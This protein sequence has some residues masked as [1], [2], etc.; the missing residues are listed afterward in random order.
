[1]TLTIHRGTHEIGGSCIELNTATTRLFLDFG[2]PL[3]DRNGAKLKSNKEIK[4]LT[5]PEMVASGMAP[6]IPYFI[7]P[8]RKPSALLLSHSH[9]D[10]YG[11]SPWLPETMPVYSSNGTKKLLAVARQFGQTNYNP[12]LITVIA[13]WKHQKIGNF[14]ITPYLADHSAVD[15]FSFLIEA[16][17]KHIFYS[18]DIRRHGRKGV[19]FENLIKSPPPNL[20]YLILEGSSLGRDT[21]LLQTEADIETAIT[22]ELTNEGLYLASFSSQNI[23]RFVSFFKACR[24]TGRTLVVDPY[25]ALILD[26]LRELSPN[27]P[28]HDW[29][30]GFKVFFMNN[31]Y[32]NIMAEDKSL[33]RYKHAKITLEEIQE[34]ASRLVIKENY[35][36]KSKLK[37]KGMLS[38]SKVIYSMWDGYLENEHFWSNNNVPLI[39]IHCS[40][41]AYKEDLVTLEA[42]L[43]PKHVIPN[44]TFHPNEFS[45]IFG[46]KTIVLDDEQELE[47]R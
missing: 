2:L 23:D 13:P 29:K 27:I 33:F 45:T 1:M 9:L 43:N 36:I 32:S 35:A 40:G 15:A 18:G 14:T 38:G 37:N 28:Q 34:S 21:T 17:G 39:K 42:A 10:H 46:K 11:L 26:T 24:A 44:H 25:T 22:K 41:H 3:V 5:H 20:D 6:S 7:S 4:P 12:Q 19:L 8:D 30:D 47:C 31:H 16:E